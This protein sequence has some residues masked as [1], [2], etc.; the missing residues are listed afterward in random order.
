MVLGSDFSGGLD[1]DWTLSTAEGLEALGQALV[2]R[3]ST[4][5]GSLE[6]DPTYGFDLRNAVGSAVPLSIIEHRTLEQVLAE[7]EIERA[8]VAATLTGGV[9]RVV[10]RALAG[11][12]P[13]RL[14]LTIDEL[15]FEH[16]LEAA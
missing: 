11:A 2:R 15:T 14:T 5:R 3:L 16:L 13:F 9:L 4:Q 8:T 1:L 7:E 12:G 6:D 10:I